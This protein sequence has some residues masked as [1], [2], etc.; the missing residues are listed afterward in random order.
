MGVRVPLRAPQIKQPNDSSK[1][2]KPS[3]FRW[4]TVGGASY[5]GWLV[6]NVL[7]V[8]FLPVFLLIE[9]AGG[10]AGVRFL[11]KTWVTFF[12]LFFVYFLAECL[13]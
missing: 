6:V 12:R 5:F 8:V 9:W 10:R 3:V 1:A 13:K 7:F 11:R 4:L 2:M